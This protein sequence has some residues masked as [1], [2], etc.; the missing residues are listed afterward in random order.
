MK[1]RNS[2]T[3]ISLRFWSW[4]DKFLIKMKIKII[5]SYKNAGQ[6]EGLTVVIDVLRAFS[7]VCFIANNGAKKII[8]L[9][10]LKDAYKLKKENPKFI[11]LGERGG[12][13][14]PE[15]DF[16]N[17]P[18]EIDG[19]NFSGKS[20]IHTTTTGTQSFKKANNATEIITGS[21][22]NAGAIIN[23]IKNKNPKIVSFVCCD[24]SDSENE[25]VL[26]AKY[27]KDSLEGN[28]TNFPEIKRTIK[29]HPNAKGYLENPRTKFS[30]RDFYLCLDLNRFKFVL[31]LEKDLRGQ[32]FLKKVKT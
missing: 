12:F 21:F 28:K 25:D 22:V 14:L 4:K 3:A 16:G 7:T 6:A 20:V 24:D 31:R 30:K 15:F 5:R 13:R 29:S 17:S 8:P 1:K 23:Y 19:L 27:L 18:A 2:Q 32:P 10:G 9:A 26:L 11:L